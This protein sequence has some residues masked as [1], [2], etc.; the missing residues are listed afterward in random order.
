MKK[1]S[2]YLSA[3]C[4]IAPAL[5]FGQTIFSDQWL[6][7]GLTNGPDPADTN[8]YTTTSSSAIEVSTGSMGLVSGGSG[9]GIHT[10]FNAQTLA[11]IGDALTLR[12]VFTTPATVGSNRSSAFR[13]G[14]FN[15]NGAAV[16]T[17]FTSST[18][19]IWD[20]IGGFLVDFDVN[21][22][23]ENVAI[24]SRIAPS[25]TGSNDRL[26]GT[27]SF[28]DTVGD[29]GDPYT[30]AASTAYSFEMMVER[31]GAGTVAVKGTLFDAGGSVLSTHMNTGVSTSS[32]TFDLIGF[33]ANSNTFGTSNSPGDPDNGLTFSSASL[34][35]TPV[36]EPSGFAAIFGI[37][38]ILW[39]KLRG[40]KLKS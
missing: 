26:L 38:S 10:T 30:F 1:L 4:A 29:G 27:T 11:S 18:D 21:T 34:V 15:S 35:F 3:S 33:H 31:D 8:W 39:L 2:Y 16:G 19:P 36:P 25:G 7:G 22:G 5:L 17:D 24:R 6:D 37:L 23:S 28:F 13:A 20:G 32:L 12:A 40:R 9:R 14:I